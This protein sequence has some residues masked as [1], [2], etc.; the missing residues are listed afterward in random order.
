MNRLFT[1]FI[2]ILLIGTGCYKNVDN[3]PQTPEVIIQTEEVYVTTRISGSVENS[4]GQT[5]SDYYISMNGLTEDVV[6]DYF[7][8]EL[9]DARKKGQT[10]RVTKGGEQIGLRTELLVENDINHM[11]IHTH[12]N[13][14][15]VQKEKSNAT[16]QLSKELSVD[17]SEA[18]FKN[19]APSNIN[20]T[21]V[22][23]DNDIKLTPVGYNNESHLLAIDSKGGFYLTSNEEANGTKLIVDP[24][25]P[26][27]LD[28]GNIDESINGL[29]VLNEESDI[30]ELV[31]DI[32]SNVTVDILAKGYYTFASYTKGVFVEGKITKDE[33]K[34]AY[35]P[36][37]WS[38]NGM[39]NGICATENGRWIGLLPEKETITLKLLNPCD[40]ALQSQA[41]E[42]NNNDLK[43][44][45]LAITNTDF[46]QYLNTNVIDCEG[47]ITTNSI[48]NI[49]NENSDNHYV[50]SEQGQERWIAVCGDF[51]IAAYDE[52]SDQ[53]GTQINWSSGL[54]ETIDVLSTCPEFA[55]GFSYFKIRNDTR[56]YT[57]FNIETTTN[58]RTRLSSVDG[59]I[60]VIFSGNG[61][62]PVPEMKVNIVINDDKF[63]DTG[64]YVSCEN[65]ELG[66]GIND[67]KVTHYDTQQNGQI[68]AVFSG[69]IWMQTLNPNLAGTYPVEGVIFSRVQ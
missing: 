16:V 24:A 30:W 38:H 44:Q 7:L 64:Y 49:T 18:K 42:I 5:I 36:M 11:V 58:G 19:E 46:Y 59:E 61:V 25:S 51:T 28:I 39:Q 20:I 23:I 56:A 68:R 45:N 9:D 62:G 55:D 8:I 65:S 14:K 12:D 41:I 10:F 60:K 27:K 69:N 22:N 15:S 43:N 3:T 1:F 35:Q 66:C 32:S 4:E 47:N 13:L 67:F 34:V 21:Y 57:A 31:S 29:F 2:T 53:L 33:H 6:S 17:F 52:S 63:G 26:V 40:E 48:L 37:N 50:F 54:N